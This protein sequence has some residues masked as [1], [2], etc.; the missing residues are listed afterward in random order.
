MIDIFFFLKKNIYF[1]FMCYEY[2]VHMYVCIHVCWCPQR[3]GDALEPESQLVILGT[4]PGHP[5]EQPVLFI[6]E[7]SLLFD[8]LIYSYSDSFQ[9]YHFISVGLKDKNISPFPE[10]YST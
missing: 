9:L 3:P 8:I 6:A 5:Q 7:S 4:E 10:G 2:F 1:C